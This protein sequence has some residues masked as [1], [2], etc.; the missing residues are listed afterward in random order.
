MAAASE[1]RKTNAAG[2]IDFTPLRGIIQGHGNVLPTDIDG[3]IEHNGKFLIF[4]FKQPGE[5][6]SEGQRRALQCLAGEKNKWCFVVRLSG[7]K[8][9]NGATLFDPIGISKVG[10]AGVGPEIPVQISHLRE[11][12]ERFWARSLEPIGDGM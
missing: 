3:L 10:P 9:E 12:I 6:L 1:I 7:V 11:V 8:A 2:M 5:K 4:E